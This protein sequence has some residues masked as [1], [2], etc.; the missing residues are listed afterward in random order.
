MERAFS[1]MVLSGVDIIIVARWDH[2]RRALLESCLYTLKHCTSTSG[3]LHLDAHAKPNT[4]SEH[5]NDNITIRRK[6]Y[7]RRFR[8][9]IVRSN[10]LIWQ[11]VS[12]PTHLARIA[13]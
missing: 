3:Y 5:I 6:H 7:H 10:I 1:E 12:I 2:L 8:P 4:Y 9:R 11:T 13:Y